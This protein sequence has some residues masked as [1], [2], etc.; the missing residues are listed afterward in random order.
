MKLFNVCAM[1]W[2][3]L[4]WKMRRK[5]FEDGMS[6]VAI[7]LEYIRFMRAQMVLAQME[8]VLHA[9]EQ[10]DEA[11]NEDELNTDEVVQLPLDR[12]GWPAI[13]ESCRV[14]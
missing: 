9:L 6:K 3:E 13:E 12:E 11:D 2:I 10:I 4:V 14:N 1:R 5:W 7:T 8:Q